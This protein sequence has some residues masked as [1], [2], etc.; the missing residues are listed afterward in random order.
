ML[1]KILKRKDKTLR[2]KC[3]KI[4]KI[5]PSI[6]KLAWS[7]VETMNALEGIGLA[8][9]Q[10]GHSIRLII[11]KNQ[12]GPQVMINP[13]ISEKEGEQMIPEGCLS[14]PNKTVINKRANKVTVR[15]T[16][17]DGTENTAFLEGLDAVVA[18]H[19]IDHLNGILMND[20]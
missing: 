20:G 2:K 11:V 12:K 4:D 14:I 13:I 8:A 5:T 15:Y 10:V 17:L 18:Q 6:K 1:L 16:C 19:E 3:A 9:N 7:M